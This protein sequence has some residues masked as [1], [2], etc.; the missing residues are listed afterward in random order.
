MAREEEFV[1]TI[2][3]KQLIGEEVFLVSI[4]HLAIGHLDKK[5]QI[6]TDREGN[7]FA[8]MSNPWIMTS[9][10]MDSL[11]DNIIPLDEM[12][13]VAQEAN[14]SL[15]NAII[16]YEE[17]CRKSPY[18]V[19]RGEDGMPYAR[20]IDA[21]QYKNSSLS[22]M[23]P[24][25]D[26]ENENINDIM[27][28]DLQQLINDIT[29]G[30][31]TKEELKTILESLQDTSDDMSEVI[32][33]IKEQLMEKKEAEKNNILSIKSVSDEIRKTIINQDDATIR[34]LTDIVQK[35]YDSRLKK[36]GILLVGER[37]VGKSELI[38]LIGKYT[39]LPVHRI[40][41]TQL[42]VPNAMI[43]SMIGSTIEEELWNLYEE[44]DKDIN[45]AEKAILFFDKADDWISPN[46]M[47]N[48]ELLNIPLEIIKGKTYYAYKNTA[49]IPRTVKINTDK[50]IVII[51][52]T[53]SKKNDLGFLTNPNMK[54]SIR[55]DNNYTIP[56]DFIGRMNVVEFNS[57]TYDSIKDI[58]MKS[59]ESILKVQEEL[60]E[61][62]GVKVTFTSD[63]ISEVAQY[64]LDQN[65]GAHVLSDVVN[66]SI[67]RAFYEVQTTP[68]YQEVI[69]NKEAVHDSNQYQLVK[70][71]KVNS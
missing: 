70:K 8:P 46:N 36:E 17:E 18:I 38:H 14:T 1:A 65:R 64:V 40:D 57:L 11:Y 5:T 4:D 37:G 58:L 22:N 69:M 21:E 54:K 28:D 25:E 6:F 55:N 39:D 59:D 62:L 56:E 33:F 41:S 19:G 67:W 44:C 51:E 7:S 71:K 10:E 43:N 3:K 16:Q 60:F 32:E 42:I 68:E 66:N 9:K 24:E 15:E 47:V 45:R 52:G 63:Y 31:Y 29:S 61:Q 2:V 27:I 35:Q 34:I 13:K 20:P 50:M 53:Y 48:P 30:K 23:T 26:N 49:R 12:E